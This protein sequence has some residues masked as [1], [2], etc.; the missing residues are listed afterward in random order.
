MFKNK[1]VPKSTVKSHCQI[2]ILI[3][4]HCECQLIELVSELYERGI[5]VIAV[6]GRK[7][8]IKTISQGHKEVMLLWK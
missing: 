3:S 4:F 7:K 6:T 5:V 2:Q 8:P 1:F